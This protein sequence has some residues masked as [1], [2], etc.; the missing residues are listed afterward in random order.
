VGFNILFQIST[1]KKWLT[2]VTLRVIDELNWISA[3]T[4]S[5]TTR[6]IMMFSI[7]DLL[8]TLSM[9]TLS[10]K[11]RYAEYRYA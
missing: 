9:T 3:M 1:N 4:F 6:S 11:F 5:I 7:R 10:V 2:G 8:E